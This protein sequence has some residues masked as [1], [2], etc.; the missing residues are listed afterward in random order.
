MGPWCP[1]GP[2]QP[3]HPLEPCGPLTGSTEVW[4]LLS[5]SIPTSPPMP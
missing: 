5:S 4:S 1:S 3:L 2:W